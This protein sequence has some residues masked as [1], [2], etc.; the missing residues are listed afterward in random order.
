M[1]NDEQ[2]IRDL[3]AK[4]NGATIAGDIETICGMIADDA[5]FHVAG[6][7]PFGK[8]AFVNGFR[9]GLEQVRIDVRSEIEELHVAGDFAYL[10]HHLWVTITPRG[11]GVPIKRTGYTL[12]IL[13]K[14]PD[15]R[16]LLARDANLLTADT[17]GSISQGA[18][19]PQS[20]VATE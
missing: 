3:V 17:T 8:E 7:D 5:V 12:T 18:V 14:Q 1:Q 16:W 15:G 2:T 10:R 19:L 4:W 6:R 11:G 20:P 13:R 9:A